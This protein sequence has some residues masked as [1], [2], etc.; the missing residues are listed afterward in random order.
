MSSA[1]LAERLRPQ[2]AADIGGQTH[3]LSA[4]MPLAGVLA[5]DVPLYSMVLWGP[6]GCGKTTVARVLAASTKAHWFSLSA[7]TAGLREV[8]TVI[9]EAEELR[10]TDSSSHQRILFVDEI[11]HFNK[12]QQDAFLPHLE[13][14]LFVLIGATTENPSFEL[15]RALLSRLTVH[16]LKPLTVAELESL[17]R[18]AASQMQWQLDDE[19]ASILARLAD[20]DARRM[21]NILEQAAA[22]G[23]IN[24]AAIEKAAGTTVRQ[25]DKGGDNFYA[26]ISA[27]HK[28]VRGSSPDAALYWLCRMLDGGVDPRYIGRRLI[29][30]ASE[31]VGLADPRALS[32]TLEADAAYRRL[33]SPEGELALAQ[34][35]VYLAC[36]P[37][38]DSVY[39]AFNE[40]RAFIK[41]DGSRPVPAR[42]SPAPT[43]LM[44]DIGHGQGYRH[45]H[46]EEGGYAAG[47]HYLPDDMAARQFYVPL[48]R[49]LEEKIKTRLEKLQALDKKRGKSQN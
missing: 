36:V 5:G 41:R 45:A 30:I 15:N 4:G 43:K 42:L 26:Q 39:R 18:R 2:T 34:A 8:R 19:A 9:A 14:G 22:K 21:F 17:V 11:H 44:K 48:A 33:G 16:L 25:F 23:D 27:L 40:T 31:D 10:Q 37:K 12:T 7:T 6:P 1:P 38:S 20:G 29:R 35:T 13:D 46:N 32:L 47:E 28:S 3:L 24:F 49:G